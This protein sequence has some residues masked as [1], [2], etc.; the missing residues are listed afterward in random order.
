MSITNNSY[1][2]KQDQGDNWKDEDF[3]S[4]E[5]ETQ[6]K[7]KKASDIGKSRRRSVGAIVVTGLDGISSDPPLPPWLTR[8][9]I[10][11]RSTQHRLNRLRVPP[12]IKLHN[13]IVQ[14]YNLMKP[15]QEEVKLRL[16]LVDE[17]R[18]IVYREFGGRDKVKVA[19][20][21][22]LKTGLFLP[23]SDIDLVVTFSVDDEEQSYANSKL[24]SQDQEDW[25]LHIRENPGSRMKR[26]A[27]AIGREW[28]PD[29]KISY[30]EVLDSARVP[31]VK[32]THEPTKLNVDVSFDKLNGQENADFMN[33]MLERMPPLKPLIFVLKA[34]TASRGL[35]EPYSGGI[36]SFLLQLMII[37]FIQHR[38]REEFN[39]GRQASANVKNMGSMLLEFFELYGIDF[40]YF[41]TVS[42][43]ILIQ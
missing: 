13:E 3:L 19:T 15:R 40:N 18:S 35:N 14:F 8:D 34:F 24:D 42:K 1:N 21:G 33:K 28:F 30:L 29:G 12:L 5:D 20:F 39:R 16:D 17:I 10:D 31:I 4:F 23:A 9:S 6:N 41:T 7:D 26:F 37:S 36:G 25:R 11:E 27:D 22:S 43:H 2:N 32:L 38:S